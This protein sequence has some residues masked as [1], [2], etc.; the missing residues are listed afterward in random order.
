MLLKENVD[1]RGSE[2]S[3]DDFKA[4]EGKPA[5]IRIKDHEKD[6][7]FEFFR[8]NKKKLDARGLSCQNSDIIEDTYL[9]LKR[10]FPQ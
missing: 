4:F 8:S 9:S 3:Y 2:G 10:I 7:Q 1:S 6:V 5:L